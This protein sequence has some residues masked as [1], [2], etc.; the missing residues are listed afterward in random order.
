MR[1]SILLYLFLNLLLAC[2]ETTSQKDNQKNQPATP[3]KIKVLDI[4]KSEI[5]K[6]I[7]IKG[8]LLLSKK[9]TDQNGENILVLSRKG[10]MQET[11][12]EVEFSGDERY[13]ELYAEQYTKKENQFTLLWDI[14]DF[15]RHCPFDLWIGPLPNS[16]AITDLDND[17]ITETTI[18]YKLSC[19]SDVSPSFMKLIMHENDIKMALRG[20]MIL[21]ID[22]DK[23]KDNYEYDLSKVDTSGL[24]EYDQY[25][26]LF[27]R[28]ANEIEFQ[29]QP[30]EFLNFAKA[31][32]KQLV[33]KD[34]FDQF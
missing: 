1:K 19:R 11:E 4:K 13:A 8:E 23:I 22:K 34:K 29:N 3:Q 14:Y 28:Y 16:T 15:E 17:G 12:F 10:P 26:A 32:W 27:G 30:N 5:P 24:S 31:S 2:G 7:E 9:W 21:D 18:A 33:D 25:E 20:T 6:S